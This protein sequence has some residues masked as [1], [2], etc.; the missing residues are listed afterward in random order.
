M[1]VINGQRIKNH[2]DNR[3]VVPYNK[4][5]LRQMNSHTNVEICSSVKCIKYVLKYVNKGSDQAIFSI[6]VEN[7]NDEILQYQEARYVGS[8]EAAY[9]I[10]GFPMHEH[11]PPVTQLSVHLEN[12][13]RV[14]FDESTAH[15]I[16][17]SPA[18]R[19]TLTEFF[20]L[21]NTDDFASTLLYVQVPEYYTWNK[22]SKKWCRRKRGVA[23]EEEFGVYASECIGRVYTVN[24]KATE[25]YFLRMLLHEV[26]GPTSFQFLRTVNGIVHPTYREACLALGLVE[27]DKHLQQA[28]REA[29]E[30]QAPRSLR[31]LFIVILLSCEPGNPIALWE[32]FKLH[33]SEDLFH[34]DNQDPTN[35]ENARRFYNECLFLIEQ[36]LLK[37]GQQLR[38]FGLP[39]VDQSL[40]TSTPTTV[41][42]LFTDY[43]IKEQL[44]YVTERE[45]QLTE[46]Q[47]TVY[48]E[49]L[50]RVDKQES[51]IMFLDAA[52][53]TGKTFLINVALAKVRSEN[54]LAIATAYSG[55]AATLITGGRTVHST[56]K[57]PINA[58]LHEEATC[59][60][61]RG[62]ALAKVIIDCSFLIIDEAPMTHRLVFEAV[63]RTLKD[64]RQNQRPFGGIPVLLCG[65]F[66]QILP[67]VKNGTRVNI[68]DAT[69]KKSPLWK[70]V[71][72][73]HLTNNMRALMTNDASATEYTEF[74]TNIGDGDY[75]IKEQPD[76]IQIPQCVNTYSSS[77]QLSQAIYGDI[78]LKCYDKNWLLDRAL[79]APLNDTVN[80]INN[81]IVQKFPGNESVYK[82]I[83]KTLTEEESVHFPVE[84]L[85][86]I[87]IPGIS[88]HILTLKMGVPVMILRSL[89]PP[90]ITNGTRCVIYKMFPNVLEVTLLN[91]PAAGYNAFIPR[92]PLTPS[93]TDLPFKFSRLQFPIRLCFSMTINKA[94]GQSFKQI[95]LNLSKPVFSHGMLYVGLS[96]VGC[97]NRL[98]LHA[99][100]GLTRNVVYKS[101]LH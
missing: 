38:D 97:M 47:R 68:L 3:Y 29:A 24:P 19:T 48:H 91:G 61:K 12:G 31:K 93:D 75:P 54:K 62:S 40:I 76:T 46:E 70:Y 9:R 36:E 86:S 77:A 1:K 58:H 80:A 51:G 60:I 73:F 16:A 34:R 37:V 11:Y 72:T 67:V 5:L 43:D 99:P 52:G 10:L 25:C 89:D 18:P 28:L 96:R 20:A 50:R 64:I 22:S 6:Q 98:H 27:D 21:C 8:M 35:E 17:N 82:S 53:G 55:I 42:R 44:Q 45:R 7:Q 49:I 66:R 71:T 85:N 83:D 87:D 100:D 59:T 15:T 84:F 101:I 88:P 74:L 2:V 94:Q 41:Y 26:R 39:S 65:D 90:N 13:Q 57:V 32:E 14:Y 78:T 81:E 4:W 92:I 30:C 69:L 79:L 23:V 95:G 56:F 63:D 33:L